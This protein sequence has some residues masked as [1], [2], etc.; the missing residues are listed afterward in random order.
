MRQAARPP[1]W[2]GKQSAIRT[3]RT[4]HVQN[5]N[6][7]HAVW[8]PQLNLLG[9]LRC[10]ESRISLGFA[11]STSPF[12]PFF[13]RISLECL[14]F[15]PQCPYH[16]IMFAGP[17]LLASSRTGPSLLQ[18][19]R[20]HAWVGRETHDMQNMQSTWRKTNKCI[21]CAATVPEFWRNSN[22][23]V[24]YLRNIT[25]CFFRLDWDSD[26]LE[27]R[28]SEYYSLHTYHTRGM[29]KRVRYNSD[30]NVSLQT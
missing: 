4:K 5:Q 30:K 8:D 7:S 20:A 24:L 26:L 19:L 13:C 1:K 3:Q 12:F 18:L 11:S 23:W 9:G 25:T 17:H 16:W 15:F 28:L 22:T 21:K 29:K 6:A 14:S 27:A 10:K 2:A